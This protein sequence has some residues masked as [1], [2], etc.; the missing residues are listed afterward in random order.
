MGIEVFENEDKSWDV[1]EEVKQKLK[2]L[3]NEGESR[4]ERQRLLQL[5][6]VSFKEVSVFEG[7]KN[8]EMM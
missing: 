3:V 7:V 8:G 1:E 6:F 5:D 4:E 2:F